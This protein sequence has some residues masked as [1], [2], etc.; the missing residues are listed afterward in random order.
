MIDEIKA[1]EETHANRL[2]EFKVG[3]FDFEQEKKIL[4]ETFR[5]VSI[6]FRLNQ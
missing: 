2:K 4:D 1:V 6:I 3:V 5:D